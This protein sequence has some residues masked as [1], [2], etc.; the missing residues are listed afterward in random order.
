MFTIGSVC[1]KKTGFAKVIQF[2]SECLNSVYTPADT[3]MLNKL[4]T[5]MRHT[6]LDRQAYFK[7]FG[8]PFFLYFEQF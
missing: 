1:Y 4:K 6:Y 8:K 3:G 7:I 5:A 2:M